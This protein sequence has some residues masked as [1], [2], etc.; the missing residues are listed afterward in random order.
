MRSSPSAVYE[1]QQIRGVRPSA[2]KKRRSNARHRA[3]YFAFRVF[4]AAL[5]RLP[6]R[7]ARA[8]AAKTAWLLLRAAGSRRRILWKNLA[9]AFPE[10]SPAEIAA[11]ARG[12]VETTARSLV[13]FL[14]VSRGTGEELLRRVEISG[15]EHLEGARARGQGVFLLSAHFGSWEIGAL[16]A[17]LLG[18][19]I[20][21]LVRP[22]DNPLL[23]AELTRRRSR[24]GNEV[25]A[26]RDAA[27]ELLRAMRRNRTVAILVDQNVLPQEAVFVPFFGRLAATTPSLALL[28]LKTG[29]AVVPVFTW[30]KGDGQYRLG[31]E[32]PI[33]SDPDRD[34]SRAEK[35]RLLTERYMSVTEAAIRGDPCAWLWIHN[36]WRTR[37]VSE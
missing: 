17:G 12:S 24:F 15:R 13:D 32:E 3:E 4:T 33:L 28:Q 9:H 29:A 6:P 7:A 35:V 18:E 36:R 30:P 25:I 2:K 37:P 26:K 19:P 21:P 10:K 31:F 16:A 20:A 34:L 22:L 14:E 1:L 5:G 23:E 8:I 27:R 11:I